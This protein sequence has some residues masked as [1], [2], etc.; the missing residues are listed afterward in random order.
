M[1]GA[2]L[3]ERRPLLLPS[4]SYT[5]QGLTLSSLISPEDIALAPSDVSDTTYSVLQGD[6]QKESSRPSGRGCGQR[7]NLGVFR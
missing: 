2:R 4:I 3:C 1:T 7:R 6:E 5:L